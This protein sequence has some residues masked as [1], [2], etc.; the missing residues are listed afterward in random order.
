MPETSGAA[1]CGNR[2]HLGVL[3]AMLVV[4]MLVP[5]PAAAQT[6]STS[7]KFTVAPY[8]WTAG[9]GGQV[10]IGRV[11][12]NVDVSFSQLL[13]HLR[14]GAMSAVDARKGAVVVTGDL[15]YVSVGGSEAFAI[16]GAS[17]AVSFDQREVILQGGVGVTPIDTRIWTVDLILGARYWDL[18]AEFGLDPTNHDARARSGN[19]H[20]VDATAGG[21]VRFSPAEAWH[22]VAD[23]DVGGGGSHNTWRLA[24]RATYDLSSRYG[25]MAGYKYLAVDYEHDGF[26][27]DT[28]LNGWQIG[29]TF[30]F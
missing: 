9:L 27:Y 24:G 22:L 17:G 14:F 19:R 30:T 29:P 23:G 3:T 28:H 1:F 4:K 16:S 13:D 10:G 7:W 25:L 26:L 18:D 20:W 6:A 5:T 2:K 8:L 15:V 21:R 12:T 11:S